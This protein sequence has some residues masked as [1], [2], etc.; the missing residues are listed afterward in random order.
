LGK[1]IGRK[2][3]LTRTKKKKNPR[4]MKEALPL[5]GRRD[6]A[7]GPELKEGRW[8]GREREVQKESVERLRDW[9]VRRGS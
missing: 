3:L 8:L 6:V 2:R 1:A 9:R 5:F 4:K 7:E